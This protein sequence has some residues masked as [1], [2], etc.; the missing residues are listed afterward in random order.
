VD[1]ELPPGRWVH[2]LTGERFRGDRRVTVSAPLGQPAAFVRA[3]DP[4][5]EGLRSRVEKA[6]L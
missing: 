5:T 1:V 6:G 3:G 2:L 4:W